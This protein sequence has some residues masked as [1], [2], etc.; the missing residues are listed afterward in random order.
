MCVETDSVRLVIRL[1]RGMTT[2]V[3]KGSTE[4]FLGWRSTVYGHW[5]AIPTLVVRGEAKESSEHES[6]I[7]VLNR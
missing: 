4:P 7:T 1:D 5:E 6:L 2:E 3:Q